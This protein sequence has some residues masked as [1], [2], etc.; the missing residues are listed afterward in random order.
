MSGLFDTYVERVFNIRINSIKFYLMCVFN[1]FFL[2]SIFLI[3]NPFHRLH[4]L[5]SS[6]KGLF[7][8]DK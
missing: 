3:F 5:Q 7:K 2:N 8:N 6:S 4:H 1:M